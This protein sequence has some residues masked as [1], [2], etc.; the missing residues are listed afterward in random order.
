MALSVR[1]QGRL[2]LL[3]AVPRD[4]RPDDASGQARAGGVMAS[5]TVGCD[6]SGTRAPDA[7]NNLHHACFY[8]VETQLVRGLVVS[9]SSC[10]DFTSKS[11]ILQG[12]R[13]RV[14]HARAPTSCARGVLCAGDP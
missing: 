14:R 4:G 13:A 9:V 7:R 3:R 11:S 6:P 8:M 1:S 5:G 12:T 2:A 10:I